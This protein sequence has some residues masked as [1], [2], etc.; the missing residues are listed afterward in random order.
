MPFNHFTYLFKA[1][2][3][4]KNGDPVELLFHSGQLHLSA[5]NVRYQKTSLSTDKP[6][7]CS[8]PKAV[9]E[10]QSFQVTHMSDLWEG[11]SDSQILVSHGSE[12]TW[13]WVVTHGFL[14]IF[15]KCFEG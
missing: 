4:L 2:Y 11:D 1:A 7:I 5:D 9:H 14:E 15:E 3:L 8:L 13:T 10:S 12:V 6:T